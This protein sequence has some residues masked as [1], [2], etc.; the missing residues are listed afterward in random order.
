ML[1]KVLFHENPTK[2]SKYL[3]HCNIAHYIGSE[4][5]VAVRHHVVNVHDVTVSAVENDVTNAFRVPADPYVYPKCT[6]GKSVIIAFKLIL[7]NNAMQT[8]KRSAQKTIE[9]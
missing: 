6:I 7:K 2:R 5:H 3:G 9:L 8:T 1:S 4:R